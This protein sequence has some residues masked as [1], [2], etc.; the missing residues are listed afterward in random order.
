MKT[1]KLVFGPAQKSAK[2]RK[3]VRKR[4]IVKEL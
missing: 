1:K 3:R 4:M 2:K